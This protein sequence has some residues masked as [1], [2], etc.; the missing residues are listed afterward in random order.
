VNPVPSASFDLAK[1]WISECLEHHESC[2]GAVQSPLPT[3]VIDVGASDEP[4][5]PKLFLSHGH[6]C[7]Y[8]ALSYCWGGPQPV[9]LTRGTINEWQQCMPIAALPAAFQDAVKV[10]RI[11]NIRYLWVDALCIIQDD[12]SDKAIEMARMDQIYQDAYVTI[13]AANSS[14]CS[15]SFLDIFIP[16]AAPEAYHFGKI[17]FPCPDGLPGSIYVEP[18]PGEYNP[19]Q[20]PLNQ[21]GWA[22]QERLLSP[23]VL[24]FGSHQMYWQ[25]QT[26]LQCD[27]GSLR[28]FVSPDRLGN[29][30]F[31]HEGDGTPQR[32][33]NQIHN[34]WCA[35]ITDYSGRHLTLSKDT[36]PA[37][38]GIAT[39]FAEI[40]DDTYCAGFWR[41]D[42][43]NSLGWKVGYQVTR[44]SEYRAPSWSWASVNGQIWWDRKD[45][46]NV[47]SETAKSTEVVNC[48][49]QP[50]Y[51]VAPFG[52][53]Q[54]GIIELRGQVKD[55][56]WDGVKRIPDA[57]DPHLEVIAVP[58]MTQETLEHG[59]GDELSEP[60]LFSTEKDQDGVA[61]A[62][63]PVSCVPLTDHRAL[64][65]ELRDDGYYTR[66]GVLDFCFR[67]NEWHK[68]TD[69]RRE[70]MEYFFKGCTKRT[71]FVK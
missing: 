41:N 60:A 70:D 61:S 67:E 34:N 7:C 20:E 43:R 31:R 35:I 66:I 16:K 69:R 30:F 46:L 44:R 24:T 3:R 25:C 19:R 9:V 64:L 23:R 22:L 59:N 50:L 38:S 39:R 55:I 63:R 42:L 54:Y 57:N 4:V 10:T 47:E 5:E 26:D 2:P 53:V 28:M 13:A 48:E 37:L 52:E 32:D 21:R 45:K 14:K 58:D 17:F 27:G 62:T 49:V 40:L 29:E 68:Q 6:R 33:F 8:T 12:D 18:S 51:P 56:D 15:K 1:R 65:L 36:L 11:L 71:I